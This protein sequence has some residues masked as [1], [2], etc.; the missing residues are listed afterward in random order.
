ME[1]KTFEDVSPWL[2]INIREFIKFCICKKKISLLK[3][4]YRPDESAVI[5]EMKCTVIFLEDM[6]SGSEIKAYS[7]LHKIHVNKSKARKEGRNYYIKKNNWNK[8][9]S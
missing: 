9:N 4:N 8:K 2:H 7:V 5:M 1:E 6:V 3:P